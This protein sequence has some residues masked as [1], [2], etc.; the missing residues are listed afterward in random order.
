MLYQLVYLSLSSDVFKHSDIE[1]ILEKARE[2]NGERNIT[3]MLL[4]RGGVFL[5]LLEGDKDTVA[6]LYNKITQDKRHKHIKTLIEIDN[7][8][9]I[10]ADWT[11]AF[12]EIGDIDLDLINE[13]LPWQSLVDNE[14]DI[15]VNNKLILE[16]LKKFRFHV[17]RQ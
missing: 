15:A 10:F 14:G 2:F 11:M 16:I 7:G 5:Q 12:K 17:N 6:S 8:E 4:Y 13:I 9:R 1:N 3:G